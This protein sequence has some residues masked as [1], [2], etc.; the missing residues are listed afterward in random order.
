MG[1]VEI[2][3]Y[4]VSIC[5]LT[6]RDIED[7]P[8]YGKQLGL[9]RRDVRKVKKTLEPYQEKSFGYEDY[10]HI[11][12]LCDDLKN[13]V[14]AGRTI[15][16]EIEEEENKDKWKKMICMSN[17]M[18]RNRVDEIKN[19]RD[20]IERKL[21]QVDSFLNNHVIETPSDISPIVDRAIKEI[22]EK[23][24]EN[25][26]NCLRRLTSNQ[27][28]YSAG[29]A[30]IARETQNN[31]KNVNQMV[32][33]D[34]IR[35][36]L[37]AMRIFSKNEILQAN[38]CWA[39]YNTTHLDDSSDRNSSKI[40]QLGGVQTILEKMKTFVDNEVLQLYCCQTLSNI[41]NIEN[42]YHDRNSNI[43]TDLGGIETIFKVLLNFSNNE[44]IQS[45]CF[46]VLVNVAWDKIE[47]IES[48]KELDG[49]IV[50]QRAADQF[51]K[52]PYVHKFKHMMTS[53]MQ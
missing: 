6:K 15:Y 37:G 8:V 24:I 31:R 41:S 48:I 43:F 33:L 19:C 14:E 22:Y 11:Y 23:D 17:C 18:T 4:T 44:K 40:V 2:I 38:C 28:V 30:V 35:T 26:L 20:D 51:P 45:S 13:A 39:L 5:N 12:F 47:H 29:C 42:Y 3:A 32:Y 27:H 52:N 16:D 21:L 34:G 7:Q 46:D 25:I 9:L 50:A 36:I 1:K 53:P 10:E 49:E